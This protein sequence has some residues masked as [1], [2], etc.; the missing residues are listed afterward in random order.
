MRQRKWGRIIFSSSV[1]SIQAAA[2]TGMSLY[3]ASKAAL[4]GYM[5][6]AAAEAG[7]DGITVNSLNLGMY[8]TQMWQHLILD[9]LEATGGAQ[10]R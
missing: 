9:K 6:V 10:C 3:S 5:R 2:Q 7:H 8:I 4:N 1:G